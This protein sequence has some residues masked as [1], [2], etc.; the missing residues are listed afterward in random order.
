VVAITSSTRRSGWRGQY[1]EG[2]GGGASAVGD[3]RMGPE[4]W[5]TPEEVRRRSDHD[6]HIG[7]G[8][9]RAALCFS[10]TAC[11]W[12]GGKQMETR[13]CFLT[14]APG[15]DKPGSALCHDPY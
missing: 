4:R 2:G 3:R 6:R 8:G 5:M 7:A 14:T 11:V 13:A 9:V 1:G 12:P 10:R 15:A